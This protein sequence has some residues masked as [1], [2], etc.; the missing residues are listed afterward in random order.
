MLQTVPRRFCRPHIGTNR[1]QHADEASSA[2]KNRPEK[3]ANGW[4]PIAEENK[5]SD[6]H[7]RADNAN[8]DVLAA[9]ISRGAFLDRCCDLLHARVASRRSKHRLGGDHAVSHGD[10]A[11][12]DDEQQRKDHRNSLY[13]YVSALFAPDFV[14]GST[15]LG[16]EI[17]ESM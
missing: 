13:I 3:E 1:N 14:T 10:E 9:K 4:N 2:R 7:D 11:R 6:H 12:H 16:S 17:N 5:K 15:G 8:G